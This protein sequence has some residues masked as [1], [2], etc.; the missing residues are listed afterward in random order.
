M[1]KC[2]FC[3]SEMPEEAHICL[4]CFNVC[5]ETKQSALCSQHGG[6]TKEVKNASR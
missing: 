6:C 5:E 1:K 2:P 4:N 3:N